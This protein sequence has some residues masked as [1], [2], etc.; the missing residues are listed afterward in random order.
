MKKFEKKNAPI[1]KPSLFLSLSLEQGKQI[2]IRRQRRNRN[3]PNQQINN[4][5]DFDLSQFGTIKVTTCANLIRNK[6]AING[7]IDEDFC[8]LCATE[9]SKFIEPSLAVIL[10]CQHAC[11]AKCMLTY[12]KVSKKVLADIYQNN[13]SDEDVLN[14]SCC[15][16]C[17]HEFS[18]LYLDDV[19]NTIV[20]ERTIE[21]LFEHFQRG[22][23]L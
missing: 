5:E 14:D 18:P 21:S 7:Q 8:P 20:K 10:P 12:S 17:R 2:I 1:F 13:N 19:C 6:L 11:C 3:T 4:V 9:W 15:S 22:I 16:I 23:V